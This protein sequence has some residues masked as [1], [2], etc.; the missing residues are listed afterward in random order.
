MP[1]QPIVAGLV[2]CAYWGPGIPIGI[3][4]THGAS[5]GSGHSVPLYAATISFVW[6]I[7]A[8]FAPTMLAGY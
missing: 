4:W 2:F 3:A 6:L 8:A 5:S 1:I 7:V